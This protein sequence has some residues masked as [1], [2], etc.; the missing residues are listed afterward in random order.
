MF[1]VTTRREFLVVAGG[2]AS[3]AAVPAWAQG[4]SVIACVSYPLAYF[5][6]RLAGG[7]ADIVFPVPPDADPSF[8]RPGIAQIATIQGADL[9]VL[10]GAGFA[11]WTTKTS[12]PRARIVD[13]SAGFADRFIATETLT[14][15]H[16]AEGAHSHTGTASYTWMDFALAANQAEALADALTK[17]MLDA[18]AQI[19]SELDLLLADLAALDETARMISAPAE[20]ISIITSHPRYQYFGRAYGL[21][22]STVDWDARETPTDSQWQAL[23]AKVAETGAQLFIWEAEPLPE[24]RDRIQEMGLVDVVFPPLA[25]RPVTGDFVGTMEGALERLKSVIAGAKKSSE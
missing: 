12:L 18:E 20:G 3:L 9:I 25:N 10:N 17:R 2:A 24:A 22:L 4:R 14:H 13:T 7:A 15:S 1:V 23:E 19:A 11:A 6:E 8:W 21:D 16:G 5:A